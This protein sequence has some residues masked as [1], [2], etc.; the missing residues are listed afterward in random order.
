[1]IRGRHQPNTKSSY[2][3][4]VNTYLQWCELYQRRPCPIPYSQHEMEHQLMLF[5]SYITMT[6]NVGW[7]V[8]NSSLYAVKSYLL[9]QYAI[10]LQTT[11][12]YMPRVKGM[13]QKRR[14]DAPTK[15]VTHIDNSQ[16]KK[17]FKHL[18][19]NNFTEANY[20]FMFALKHNTMRRSDEVL[21][22]HQKP[23]GLR[24]RQLTWEHGTNS[25]R[26]DDKYAAITFTRSKTNKYG[27]EQH[28]VMTCI[29]P[30][31]CALCELRNVY[32]LR[33]R[34][35]DVMDPLIVICVK[36]KPRTPTYDDW[37][38]KLQWLNEQCQLKPNAYTLHGCRGGGQDDAKKRGLSLPTIMQQSGW[39]SIQTAIMYER[40]RGI[41]STAEAIMREQNRNQ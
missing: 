29:C 5:L 21:A 6:K 33:S 8:L 15:H 28:A 23:P 35:W 13:I 10:N 26:K 32:R 30:N 22:R 7:V 3:A 14:K 2:N 19:R 39:R 37:R 17:Y 40:K 38:N 18:S 41:Q 4:H 31:I 12:D 34:R 25:P 20:R 27:E 9:E 11:K 24:I 1:M 36:G 16:L